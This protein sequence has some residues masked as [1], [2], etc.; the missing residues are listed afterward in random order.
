MISQQEIGNGNGK[1]TDYAT[2][3]D[4]CRV[5]SENLDG[6][7]QLSLLLTGDHEKAEQCLVAGLEDSVKTNNVFRK[8]AHSWAKRTVIKN[9][10]RV[11]RPHPCPAGSSA[12]AGAVS[13]KRKLLVIRDGQLEMDSVRALEDFERFVYVMTVLERYSDHDC[14]L[15]LSC[16]IHEVRAARVSALEEIRRIACNAPFI[17][18]V[19]ST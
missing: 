4:F 8:W 17:T 12:P 5:F 15:L 14:A 18:P 3:E 11:V 2:H 9:A 6:L 13:E 10:I 19:V 16:S 1:A 7:Y